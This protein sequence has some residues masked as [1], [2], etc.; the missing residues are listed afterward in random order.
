[1]EERRP[2]DGKQTA[3]FRKTLRWCFHSELFSGRG[4]GLTVTKREP[5]HETRQQDGPA[6][7]PLVEFAGTDVE[8]R[9]AGVLQVCP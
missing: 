1:M 6:L 2:E 9:A 3:V 8:P 7:Q 4:K 5:T